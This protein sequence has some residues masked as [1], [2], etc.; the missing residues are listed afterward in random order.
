MSGDRR[1]E[2]GSE[3]SNA[4]RPRL[5]RTCLAI[6][7][8]GFIAAGLIANGCVPRP[9]TLPVPQDADPVQQAAATAI[10]AMPTAFADAA[11]EIANRAE[12][13]EFKTIA[14][15][16]DAWNK[17]N[18]QIESGCMKP[19]TDAMAGPLGIKDGAT[20]DE[21]LDKDAA[22]KVARESAKG[23]RSK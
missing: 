16:Y 12:N 11:N 3:V 9:G 4:S 20:G 5:Y 2:G 15:F 14:D 13:G 19:W 21:P 22:A 10:H 18:S 8:A 6:F 23:F 17:R 1:A 7:T